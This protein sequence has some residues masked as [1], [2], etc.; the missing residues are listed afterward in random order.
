M[1][2]YAGSKESPTQ[3][4]CGWWR[5]NGRK[6]SRFIGRVL[7]WPLQSLSRVLIQALQAHSSSFTQHCRLPL[8]TTGFYINDW[9]R[10]RHARVEPFHLRDHLQTSIPLRCR[11]KIMQVQKFFRHFSKKQKIG[12]IKRHKPLKGAIKMCIALSVFAGLKVTFIRKTYVADLGVMIHQAFIS[13][14]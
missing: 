9:P 2:F 11:K 4:T 12:F 10:Y 13:W 1:K 3:W 14:K 5:Q 7:E 8:A 6:T